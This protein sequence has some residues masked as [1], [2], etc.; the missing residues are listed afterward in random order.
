MA[1]DAT[2]GGLTANC[3]ITLIDAQAYFN[4]RVFADDWDITD[5][6]ESALITA[7]MRLDQEL[8]M[9][10]RATETQALKWPRTGVYS[11]GVLLPSDSIPQKVKDATC[12]LALTLAGKNILE[13][14]ELAQFSSL[15][16]GPISM[17]MNKEFVP[18]EALPIQVARLLRGLRKIAI[19]A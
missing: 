19:V 2:P 10:T 13:P 5:E 3:Y 1:I 4:N 6:Q 18:S 9:G 17:V 12:E 11:D 14:T 7:T 8:F 15:S 16:V